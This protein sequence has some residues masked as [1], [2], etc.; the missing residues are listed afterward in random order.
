MAYEQDLDDI[1]Y[2]NYICLMCGFRVMPNYPPLDL[3]ACSEEE[4]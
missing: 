3:C 1:M 2:E 4:E